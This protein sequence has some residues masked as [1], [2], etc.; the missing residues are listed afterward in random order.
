M[1][2]AELVSKVQSI[3]QD[4]SYTAAVITGFLNQAINEIAGTYR[5]QT[6][7]TEDTV[8]TLAD[9]NRVALPADYLHG[10]Y[11]V[12]DGINII[13]EPEYYGDYARLKRRYPRRA[14]SGSLVDVAVSGGFLYYAYREAKDLTL[15]YFAAPD[16]LSVDADTPSFLPTHLHEPLLV[17]AACAKIYDLIEDGVDDPKTNTKLYFA[18]YQQSL[19]MLGPYLANADG[20]AYVQDDAES[21]FD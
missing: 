1:T 5:I 17:N 8:T 12:E 19:G 10:L 9:A 21:I 7:D 6:L 13:G 16:Q 2:R 11:L 3:V 4:A 15:S 20:P 14:D 18:K